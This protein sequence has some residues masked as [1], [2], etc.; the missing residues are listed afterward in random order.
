MPYDGAAR[1]GYSQWLRGSPSRESRASAVM[2]ET[3]AVRVPPCRSWLPHPGPVLLEGESRA[4][5]HHL[6][7][8]EAS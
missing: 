3:G 2:L 8:Q 4:V 7:S 5:R 1:S 6:K